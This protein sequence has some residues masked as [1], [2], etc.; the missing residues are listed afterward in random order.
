M[1]EDVTGGN[2]V[3]MTPPISD[4]F[5]GDVEGGLEKM[6]KRLLDLTKRNRLLNYKYSK[7][8][9]LRV[10]DELPN[11]LF[12]QLVDG[13]ELFFKPVPRP[14]G[15]KGNQDNGA[16]LPGFAP[17]TANQHAETLGI[18]TSFDLPDP[19]SSRGEPERRHVDPDIQTLHYPEELETILRTLHSSARLTIEETG[20]NML[21]LAFGFLDWYESNES[22]QVATAPLILLP[23]SLRRA[24]PDARTRAYRYGIQH[25]GED[26]LANISLQ[27]LLKQDFS[28]ALPDFGEDDTPESYF[29][30]LAPILKQHQRWRLRRHVTLTLLSFGKLLMYRDLDPR[31]W[32]QGKGPA[33]HKRVREFFEGRKE[34]SVDF[35]DDYSLDAA[36]VRSTV[37]ELVDEADSSQHSALVDAV[38]GKNLVISGPPGTGKSQ[39]ITN[40]IAA[41]M[42]A[43]KRVLFVSEKLAALEVVRHRLEK[44]G[45]GTFC[46]E[47][48]SHKSKKRELL[49]DIDQRLKKQGKFQD[50]VQLEDKLKAL[51]ETKRRLSEYAELVNRPFGAR[52]QKLFDVIWAAAR[53]RAKM[54]LAGPILSQQRIENSTNLTIDQFEEIEQGVAQYSRHL[55][56]VRPKDASVSE[57]PWFGVR[58]HN[59]TFRD[60]AKLTDLVAS[61]KQYLSE[62]FAAIRAANDVI[63]PNETWI[64]PSIQDLNTVTKNVGKVS[65][66]AGMIEDVL[67][68]LDRAGAMRRV[69]EFGA[70][71]DNWNARR[72]E[73]TRTFGQL[74]SYDVEAANRIGAA[75]DEIAVVAPAI[76][77]SGD[78][79]PSIGLLE[80]AASAL[81][82]A[83]NVF[84]ECQVLL[85]GSLPLG[86]T[87]A[88]LLG[89]IL[90]AIKDC[91]VE[92][93]DLR[94]E[95]LTSAAAVPTLS[96]AIA[97]ADAIKTRL[98][99]ISKRVDVALA[100]SAAELRDH[101]IA[102]TD[103]RWWSF[104]KSDHRRARKIHRA[105]SRAGKAAADVMRE[106]FRELFAIDQ[107][108]S[109]FNKN[110]SYRTVAGQHRG[111]DAP[112]KE[113]R[114]LAEWRVA[115]E[116]HLLTKGANAQELIEHIWGSPAQTLN[117]FATTERS[118][119]PR[120]QRLAAAHLLVNDARASTG[121]A[122]LLSAKWDEV[123][124]ALPTVASRLT[125]IHQT[126]DG[127]GLP[128]KVSVSMR[129]SLVAGLIEQDGLRARIENAADI[130]EL[131]GD[132]YRGTETE[133]EGVRAAVAYHKSVSQ[134]LL[135]PV[136]RQWLLQK[137]ADERL[138]RVRRAL[139][140]AQ[141]HRERS[142]NAWVQFKSFTGLNEQ[143]WF[144]NSLSLTQQQLNAAVERIDLARANAN[145]L[146]SWLDYLRSAENLNQRKLGFLVR[147]AEDGKLSSSLLT[148]ALEY[149]RANS[150]VE[151]AFESHPQLARFTGLSHEQI[152]ARY[153]ELDKECISLYR[154]RA[155]AKISRRPVPQG[156][157]YGH[158]SAFTE[159][160]LL[161]REIGKQKR[162]IPL[163]Q[164]MTRAGNA[165]QALKPCFMMGPLSVAQYLSPGIIAFDLLIVDEASQLRPQD[166]LGAVA[167]ASQVVIVGDQ[168]QL[169]PTSFFERLGDDEDDAEEERSA[170][171]D[172]E[173]ILDVASSLYRPARMLKWHYRSRHGSLIAFSNKEFYKNELIVFPAPVPKSKRLGVKFVHVSEGVFDSRRNIVEAKRIVE[174]ALKHMAQSPTETLGIVAMNAPQRELIEEMLEQKLKHH[175]AAEA[176][177]RAADKGLEPVF[178]KNLE[179][180]QGDER[181]V[182]YIS[183]TYGRNAQDSFQ[184]RLGPIVGANGH[185]RLNVLFTR[186][187][188]RVVLFSSIKAEDIHVD[189]GS[190]WGL[191]ALKGYL[192]YAETGILDTARF[193]GREPDS[194]FEIEVAT[195]LQSHG[196]EVAAQV[197]VAGFVLD[198]AVKHPD[199]I[200][201][202]VLGIECDGSTYHSSRSARDRDRLRQAVLEDLGWNIHRVWSTD[203]FKQ[204]EREVE[205]I[206]SRVD[207]IRRQTVA[208]DS[209]DDEWSHNSALNSLSA[210]VD[211]DGWMSEVEWQP[212]SEQQALDE[213]T[214]LRDTIGQTDQTI[215]AADSI[216]RPAM[217]ALVVRTKPRNREDWQ[218]DVP[219]EERISTN[220]DH[221]MHYLGRV[222]AITSRMSRYA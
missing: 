213:L 109:E 49:D 136:L 194:D 35:A 146:P 133:A 29:A 168:M 15:H 199:K 10:V 98:A 52:H 87:T 73:L 219:F 22:E 204:P 117:V 4:F 143:E 137:G 26:I 215:N 135:P 126:L 46:L 86:D 123:K 27:E 88:R 78:L 70:W 140:D 104:L 144:G 55:D 18:R 142:E 112:F 38:A 106:D 148:Q 51:E 75:L 212:L 155:A 185:R 187:R 160:E 175:P 128:T 43:G 111:I 181:D 195:A 14:P 89:S 122:Q 174:S 216:L 158:A 176:F 19:L 108:R 209:P 180:V 169:P 173:S 93:L 21:Y 90:E 193:T 67:P 31:T 16:H 205:R 184:K 131:L 125:G 44:L 20:T 171:E 145:S 94:H 99:T 114:L 159:R 36:P 177:V 163:R 8:G 76:E 214:V 32:P 161:D 182:I 58:N 79:A 218:R 11:E 200:D 23:A 153:A 191:R 34:T 156:V 62:L 119:A 77:T 103:I 71:L 206:L 207:H 53:A 202:F 118:T 69:S 40:L 12:T 217:M 9:A 166:A 170:I 116:R 101:V 72:I 105:I 192:A 120:L 138:H 48:H 147:L 2:E 151:E 165:I 91:P 45:L 41:A 149:V 59:L 201:A 13:K 61:T 7:K 81:S 82:D 221:V 139:A 97:E 211:D 80:R 39:T 50:P 198:L 190:S 110:S 95:G 54:G 24:E 152:R 37:P 134:A 196:L 208:E 25:S 222:I 63:E 150:L 30:N 115:L 127:L 102:T 129:G 60:E 183:A 66:S 203:W 157:G 56:A 33:D 188:R 164:L 154:R 113:L 92:V 17:I 42:A 178:V 100:P 57:H 64:E 3:G 84:Q 210:S 172:S 1:T 121:N 132:G 65:S 130:R 5:Q 28:V 83:V 197:G 96:K 74:R 47:L 124:T 6:R 220:G 162:H 179:N 186:A 68:K 85:G 167:R 141:R 107:A 189:R